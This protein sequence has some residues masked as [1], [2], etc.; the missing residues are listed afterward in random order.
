MFVSEIVLS[1]ISSFSFREI[2]WK[3]KIVETI[4]RDAWETRVFNLAEET[5]SDQFKLTE[6]TERPRAPETLNERC[7]IFFYSSTQLGSVPFAEGTRE[8]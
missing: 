7:Q 8:E 5:V 4:Y 1:V 6:S 2:L 3:K